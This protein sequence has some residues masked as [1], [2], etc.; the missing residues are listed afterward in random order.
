MTMSDRHPP[1]RRP[2]RDPDPATRRALILV[3]TV[4]ALIVV[5]LLPPVHEALA[6]VLARAGSLIA[7]HQTAGAILF[8]G[9]AAAAAMLA[10]VSSAV[11]V[12]AALEVWSEEECLVMLWLGWIL[13]GMASYGIAK[14]FGRPMVERI[15]SRRTLQRYESKI[16][17]T[18]SFG[19]L[20]LFQLA[21]PS[22]LPGYLFGLARYRF[23]RYL[24]ALAL[25]ELPYAVAT[26]YASSA[27]LHRK[28]IPL[29]VLVVFAAMLGIGAFQSLKRRW[30][31]LPAGEHQR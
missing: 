11:L 3:V 15:T 1:A 20:L 23:E 4:L 18:T 14:F 27:F 12:P 10:F 28:L 5:A 26:I 22:E 30:D 13:G 17:N 21:V 9:L 7:K 24:A 29:I 8:I 19:L 31:R 16:T 25:A 6:S 2:R